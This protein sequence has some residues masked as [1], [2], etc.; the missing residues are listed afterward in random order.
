MQKPIDRR[1]TILEIIIW[2][3]L[4]LSILMAILLKVQLG[5]DAVLTMILLCA[6]TTASGMLIEHQY[7]KVKNNEVQ[8]CKK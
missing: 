4:G 8:K 7:H 6:S 1:G 5:W 3:T 2:A